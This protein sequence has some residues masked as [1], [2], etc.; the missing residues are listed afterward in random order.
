V[1]RKSSRDRSS[2]SRGRPR[3]VRR[4]SGEGE[5]TLVKVA[6]LVAIFAMVGLV[7]NSTQLTL[8]RGI[9]GWVEPFARPN[10]CE[11]S[12]G[13]T[14]WRHACG[15]S[16]SRRRKIASRNWRVGSKKARQS[17]SRATASRSSIWS[18]IGGGVGSRSRPL[19]HSSESM[20]FARSSRTLQTISMPPCPRTLCCDRS[21]EPCGFCL[22]NVLIALE[23]L[24]LVTIDRAL[25]MHPLAWR[26]S[27]VG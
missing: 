20:E 8:S 14:S 13:I 19:R 25:L 16:R 7:K 12:C 21:P 3:W 6:Q 15:R 23:N 11:H 10:T 17:S 27:S 24:R 5:G 22:T 2:P 4:S 18:R 1:Q 9:V 26:A